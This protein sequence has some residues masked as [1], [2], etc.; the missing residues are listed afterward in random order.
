MF[1]RLREAELTLRGQKCH[2]GLPQ[3]SYLG[4]IFSANGV[5]PDK[6]K[7]Q[8][9]Q[10]WP[11]PKDVIALRQF[12]GFASYYCRYIHHFADVTAPLHSLTQT[13]V[14]LE[15]SPECQHAW[16]KMAV[17]LLILAGH[18]ARQRKTIA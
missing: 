2:I 17:W 16:K 7:V 1:R 8:A 15:L 6:E 5:A 13:G 18:L 4:H 11:I 9:V 12:L 3:V 14:S 10:D